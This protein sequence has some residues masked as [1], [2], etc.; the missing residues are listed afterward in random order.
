MEFLDL[1]TDLELW[2]YV[3]VTIVAIAI[4]LWKTY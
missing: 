2:Q 4:L 3:V 1:S